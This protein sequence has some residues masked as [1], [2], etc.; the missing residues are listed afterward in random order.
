L[1]KEKKKEKR[2]ECDKNPKVEIGYISLILKTSAYFYE[3]ESFN[4]SG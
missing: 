3:L 4:R 1:K 2:F